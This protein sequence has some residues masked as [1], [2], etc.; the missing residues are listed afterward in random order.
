MSRQMQERSAELEALALREPYWH[1][2]ETFDDTGFVRR[3]IRDSNPCR[4]RERA[5]S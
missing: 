1:P 3:P 5:V 4:R 2:P